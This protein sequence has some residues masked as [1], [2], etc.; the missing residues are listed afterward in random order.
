MSSTGNKNWLFA[1]GAAIAVVGGAMILHYFSNKETTD[2]T[3]LNEALNEIAALGEPK[4]DASGRLAFNY[5][6]QVFNIIMKNA[7]QS[8]AAEKGDLLKKRRALL[9]DK[10]MDEYKA[11]V[12]EM[13]QK[14]ERVGADLLQEAMEHIGLNE[15]EFMATHQYYMM[16]PQT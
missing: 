13:I 3:G 10:K 1:I 2:S 16:N 6:K 11:V 5:Y 4:R 15:Q 7:K 9:K 14:E 12:S 8:F